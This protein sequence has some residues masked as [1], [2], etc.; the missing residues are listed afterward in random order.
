METFSVTLQ[1][2]VHPG[3]LLFY[4]VRAQSPFMYKL[5]ALAEHLRNANPSQKHYA[6]V[7]IVGGETLTKIEATWPRVTESVIDWTRPD[8][9]LWRIKGITPEQTVKFLQFARKKIGERY[10]IGMFC[11]GVFDFKH[12]EI[13]TTLVKKAACHAKIPLAITTG[14]FL[15]PDELVN[16]LLLYKIW[17]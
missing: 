15:T 16:D 14:D 1:Q 13:C 12:A 4:R 11:L 17:A 9:E 6:H 3:D 8:L 2:L 5:I 10:D 7:A